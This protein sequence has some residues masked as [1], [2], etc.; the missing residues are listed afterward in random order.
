VCVQN[1]FIYFGNQNLK[2][3]LYNVDRISRGG[4]LSQRRSLYE[5]PFITISGIYI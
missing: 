1:R 4:T 5:V 2:T 3:A